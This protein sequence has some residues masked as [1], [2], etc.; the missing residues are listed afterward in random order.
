MFTIEMDYNMQLRIIN[1]ENVVYQYLTVG[2]HSVLFISHGGN[3]ENLP[4]EYRTADT[5]IMDYVCDHAELLQCDELIYTGQQNKR[6]EKNYDS[7]SEICKKLRPL[8]NESYCLKL[9]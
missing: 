4:A 6:W 9:K 3:I 7:L 1:I 2:N 5:I 8:K